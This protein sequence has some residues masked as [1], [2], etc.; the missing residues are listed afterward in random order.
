[1]TAIRRLYLYAVALVSLE[2]VLWGSI[3]LLRS[4]VERNAIGASAELLAGALSLVL[5]GVPVFLLHWLLAQR[6]VLKDAEERPARLRAV[7]L[8]TALLLTL[9]P[10]IQNLLALLIR[11]LLRLTGAGDWEALVGSGQSFLD[12]LVALFVNGGAAFY[13]YNI[14]RGDWKL[15]QE[16]DEFLDTRRIYRYVW[17]LY[18]LALTTLGIQMIVQSL[19]AALQATAQGGQGDLVNGIALL[20]VGAS[21]WLFVDR[22]L[23][24]ALEAPQERASLLR[25]AIL[26]LLTF[27]SVGGLLAGGAILL[28][29]VL[30]AILGEPF[31][32]SG[33]LGEISDPLSISLPL[34][35]IWL[36]YGRTLALHLR[37]RPVAV[38]AEAKNEAAGDAASFAPTVPRGLPPRQA[39]LRRLYFYGLALLGLAAVAIG[40]HLLLTTVLDFIFGGEGL[41]TQRAQLSAGLAALAVGLPVWI[42]AW[43]P[44]A[45]EAG[46]EGEVGDHARR[47]LVRKG[48][49]YLVLFAGVMGVMVSTGALLFHVLSAALGDPPDN[50]LLTVLRNLEAVLL[51]AALLIIHGRALR[52]DS[53]I[54]ERTLA[55]RHAQFPVLLLAPDEGELTEVMVRALQRQAPSLPVAVHPY[56]QGAPGEDLS[57]ARAVILPAELAARPTEALRLWLQGFTG[58]RLVIPL[59]AR[60]WYWMGSGGRN[61]AAIARQTAQTVRGLA[62][63]QESPQWRESS[64]LTAL[65]YIAAGLFLLQ[66]ILGLIGFTASLF[67]N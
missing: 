43:L 16:P 8:Y 23:Q 5:V 53:R 26:Y 24:S 38:A 48:Y 19:L 50:L 67:L 54:A 51:F 49:L 27:V 10:V 45:S 6:A 65:V 36:Y 14:L 29:Y 46:R 2:V 21:L 3:R 12:N 34:L 9:M 15:F 40:A 20:L 41:S 37:A 13:F 60:G 18:S 25:W 39:G 31:T 28:Y 33:F 17:L 7:F 64:A 59:P 58:A 42:L 55:R 32:L 22:A 4:I 63:G 56:S 61:L 47:S 57:T 62:E 1:M 52:A 30:R 11:L 35:L 66:L 44:M